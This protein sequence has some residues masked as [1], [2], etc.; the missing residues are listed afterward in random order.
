[1]LIPPT[2]SKYFLYLPS[3]PL[4]TKKYKPYP[5]SKFENQWMQKFS[6]NNLPPMNMMIYVK[7]MCEDLK[8][9]HWQKGFVVKRVKCF[10]GASYYCNVAFSS[11]IELFIK[12]LKDGQNHGLHPSLRKLSMKTLFAGYVREPL[13]NVG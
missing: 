4:T 1:M 9:G 3:C 13:L 2:K 8:I 6:L 5:P 11:T 7:F 10:F 12:S